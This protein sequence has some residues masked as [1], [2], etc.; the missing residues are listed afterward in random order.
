MIKIGVFGAG[1]LGSI[2]LQLLQEIVDFEVVGIYDSNAEAGL[3]IAQILNVPFWKDQL[4]LINACDAIDIVTPIGEHYE[5]AKA[6]MKRFKHVFIEKPVTKTVEEARSL[7]ALARE[8]QVKAQV[9]HQER[10]NPAFLAIQ[11]LNIKPMYIEAQRLA[12]WKPSYKDSSVILDLMLHDIDVIL[13]LV[14]HEVKKVSATGVAVA[15]GT[16]DIANARIEFNNGCVA[17][18]SASRIALENTRKMS[19][20]QRHACLSLDFLHQKTEVFNIVDESAPTDHAKLQFEIQTEG[21][22]KYLTLATPVLAPGN[23]IRTELEA[24]ATAIRNDST[25][26]VTLEQ[27]TDALACAYLIV[28][29]INH[30]CVV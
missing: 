25:P 23:A 21:Q 7:M 14:P 20:F 4:A 22:T 2:H 13:S 15:N 26:L 16:P 3:E 5:L 24:F 6:A 29:K 8:A 12:R 30:L 27:A 11:E 18:L 17:N 1:H 10:F 28:E 19:I 9:G